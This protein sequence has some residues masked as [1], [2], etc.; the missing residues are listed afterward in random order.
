MNFS[1]SQWQAAQAVVNGA[2]E[3]GDLNM[4]LCAVGDQNGIVRI[5]ATGFRDSKRSIP[6][7]TDAIVAIA[8]MT[9]L[10]T[11][12]ATLQL[13][14]GGRL[15]LDIPIDAYLPE[16]KKMSV[17]TGFNDAGEAQ[18]VAANRAPTA[19]ELMT[20]TSG[21]V[22]S[23]WNETLLTAEDKGIVEGVLGSEGRFLNAPLAFQPGERWEYGIGIDWLGA[24]V[25]RISG[26]RL[27]NYFEDHIFYP[28]GMTDTGYEFDAKKLD[29]AVS[30]MMRVDGGLIEAPV[31]QATPAD[32]GS[33][34]FYSGGGELYSTLEDYS[35]IL[36]A[37]LNGGVCN[38]AQ[39]LSK[40]TVASM[41]ENHIGHL[42]V[43][44]GRTQMPDLSNDFDMGFGAP[45]K[46]GLGFLRH[47]T[48]T[49]N[50]RSAGSVSWAG[51]FNSYYWIDPSSG[52]FGLF[53]T[54]ILPFYD[55]P[56]INTLCAFERAIYGLE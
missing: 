9:K 45:A 21:Y 7:E 54:Q 38:G 43:P 42:D 19:R 36:A 28:L 25:E 51:L 48:T 41:F 4:A 2:T 12:I 37:L 15:Q 3:T 11:T 26:Q 30:M 44:T 8:S 40:E 55:T 52:I 31:M 14:E 10:I 47:E 49:P 32:R 39:L 53:A 56:S 5:H 18:Y 27:L 34:A 1:D 23:I 24:L 13:V 17:L 29:R 50:G 20:H 22:Y 33:S 16:L 46:W 35:K 6:A